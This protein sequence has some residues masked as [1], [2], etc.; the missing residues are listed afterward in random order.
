VSRKIP[1]TIEYAGPATD[2][3]SGE[4]IVLPEGE[5][6]VL[7]SF[8]P[9]PSVGIFGEPGLIVA[10]P[11]DPEGAAFISLSRLDD[12]RGIPD[13]DYGEFLDESARYPTPA[14]PCPN[15]GGP[16]GYPSDHAVGCPLR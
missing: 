11:D 5:Y 4:E 9:D 8:E 2:E 3:N 1:D 16:E 7:D 14:T 15:C 12:Y 6:E 13:P 10:L